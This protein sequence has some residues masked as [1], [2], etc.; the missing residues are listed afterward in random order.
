MM[1]LLLCDFL[2]LL[3]NVDVGLLGLTPS[4]ICK[5]AAAV[6]TSYRRAIHRDHPT[7]SL[8]T[9]LRQSCRY[10]YDSSGSVEP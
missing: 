1:L 10:V 8:V 5:G 2:L 4:G 6:V 9:S 3:R 7:H